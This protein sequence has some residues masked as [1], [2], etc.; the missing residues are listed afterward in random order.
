[1]TICK[2]G[3]KNLSDFFLSDVVRNAPCRVQMCC[4]TYDTPSGTVSMAY[5]ATCEH[6]MRGHP[7]VDNFEEEKGFDEYILKC[8]QA[9][10]LPKWYPAVLVPATGQPGYDGMSEWYERTL[11]KDPELMALWLTDVHR[12]NQLLS[13]EREKAYLTKESEHAG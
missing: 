10:A 6:L 1:M 12:W 9:G 13:F 7:T 2:Y 3:T 5:I 4:G 11:D 8:L